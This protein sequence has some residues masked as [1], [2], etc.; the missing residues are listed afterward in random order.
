MYTF[1][2]CKKF[3]TYWFTFKTYWYTFKDCEKFKTFYY[4]FKTYWYTFKDKFLY[5]IFVYE[6]ILKLS[7]EKPYGRI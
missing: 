4:T 1:K 3:K 5:K 2:D 6:R 7:L